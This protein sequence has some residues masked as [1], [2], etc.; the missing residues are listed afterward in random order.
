MPNFNKDRI[1]NESST[2]VLMREYENLK[3]DYTNVNAIKYKALYENQSL[4]FI[5][6]NSRYIFAE[7]MRGFDFYKNI[8]LNVKIPL[9]LVE[10]EYEKV[11]QYVDENEKNMSEEMCFM[12]DLLLTILKQKVES[13]IHTINLY[14]SSMERP[15]SVFE[16]YD[17]LY[18]LQKSNGKDKEAFEKFISFYTEEK[19]TRNIIDAVHLGIDGCETTEAELYRYLKECYVEEPTTEGDYKLNMYVSNVLKR[20]M[21][22][23]YINK[24]VSSFK[25]MNLRHFI[26]GLSGITETDLTESVLI[27]K[28]SEFDMHYSTPENTVNRLFEDELYSEMFKEENIEEKL[29]RLVCERAIASMSLGFALLDHEF[30]EKTVVSNSLIERICFE[31]TEIEKIPQTINEQIKFLE[32]V[33]ENIENEIESVSE[34]YFAKDGGPS[35]IVAREIGMQNPEEKKKE[36]ESSKENKKSNIYSP[37]DDFDEEDDE[38]EITE[39]KDDYPE[40][41]KPEKKNIFQRVQNKA[42]DA[43]VQ[44]KKKVAE[45]KRKSVDVKN[46]GKAVAKI[47]MSVTDSIKKTVNDWDEMDDNRRKEYIIKP[48]FRK[49]YFRA[50]K[51]CIMHYGAFAINPV[52]NIVL[53]ICQKFS[54]TKDVRIRNELTRELKAEIKVTEEKIDDAKAAGDNKQKYQLMRIKEKLEAELVRVGAN[55]KFI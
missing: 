18:I 6:Q 30:Y 49:K 23:S 3:Q 33:I 53:F 21:L 20:M 52:L 42:I 46:A 45:G 19:D 4:L 17:A 15:E 2:K 32:S 38:S 35:K 12:Y 36:L 1:F 34:S 5:L 25:N 37:A 28:V 10:N 44:F 11:R 26:F 7:P 39:K 47:P 51:L 16:Y 9:V 14:S 43:N 54:N 22:D 41:E 8:I 48:G 27:E 31:S 13:L 29:N 55:S 40:V 24:G 50:L